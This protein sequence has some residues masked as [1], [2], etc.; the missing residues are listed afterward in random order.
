MLLISI[1]NDVFNWFSIWNIYECSLHHY[2][3]RFYLP[4]A[5]LKLNALEHIDDEEIVYIYYLLFIILKFIH[6]TNTMDKIIP[7]NY[8]D[9]PLHSANTF[10]GDR[11]SECLLNCE[12]C[13]QTVTFLLYINKYEYKG[14]FPAA[15]RSKLPLLTYSTIIIRI[16]CSAIRYTL[17]YIWWRW[18]SGSS[19][20]D[21]AAEIWTHT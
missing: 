16:G 7:F 5:E 10:S 2:K 18:P 14:E 8:A 12:Q 4:N 9:A 19:W 6:L 17:C 21:V 13:T 20:S 3:N 15:R 1:F 11:M